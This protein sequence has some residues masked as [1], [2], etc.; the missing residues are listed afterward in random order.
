MSSNPLLINENDEAVLRRYRHPNFVIR[1][2]KNTDFSLLMSRII[3]SFTP[4]ASGEEFVSQ[5]PRDLGADENYINS[6]GPF[7]TFIIALKVMNPVRQDERRTLRTDTQIDAEEEQQTD[8]DRV[9]TSSL[10]YK[11]NHF[12]FK[13]FNN[14]YKQSFLSLQNS[15]HQ[16]L[17]EHSEENTN[18]LIGL[19]SF[20][21]S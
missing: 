10:T 2:L 1:V 7:L 13:P 6:L 19:A 18:D 5:I 4:N 14:R 8:G 12:F 3:L 16:H 11:D 21:I 9:Q 15:I 17:E 20:G